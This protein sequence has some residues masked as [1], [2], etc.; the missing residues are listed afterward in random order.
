[1]LGQ[2]PELYAFPELNLFLTD[3]IATLI[4]W[5]ERPETAGHYLG[6]LTRAIAE[7]EFGGQG[8][9][10]RTLAGQWLLD[11]RDWETR[12][13]FRWL[14]SRVAPRS[15]I[16]K[17]P[18]T[19]L[20]R[21]SCQRATTMSTARFL[22]LVRHPVP[23]IQSLA[24][25]VGD[26]GPSV[27][28]FFARLWVDCQTNILQAL[29]KDAAHRACLVHGESVLQ[30]PDRILP[31]ITS[32]LG[33]SCG[34]AELQG[35][36]HPER[37]PFAWHIPGLHDNDVDFLDNPRFRVQPT[38]AAEPIARLDLGRT[39]T[40]AVLEVTSRLGYPVDA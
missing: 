18:R 32:W 9:E 4:E 5:D 17:S 37:S 8:S 2:H 22:H 11:H 12:T 35:M 24:A 29:S 14:T 13:I 28:R 31:E 10:S 23:T 39:L 38:R 27:N 34:A 19:A 25:T 3:K 20:A 7:L 21:S 40:A 1:M 26:E 6:G 36:K 30:Q 15:T 16:D 33:L